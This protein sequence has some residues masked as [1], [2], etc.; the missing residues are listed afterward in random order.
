MGSSQSSYATNNNDTNSTNPKNWSS[1]GRSVRGRKSIQSNTNKT[2]TT[3]LG[4]APHGLRASIVSTSSEQ[5]DHHHHNNHPL[6]VTSVESVH[7]DDI[8]V[9][10]DVHQHPKETYD[11]VGAMIEPCSDDDDDDDTVSSDDGKSC[12]KNSCIIHWICVCAICD[13]QNSFSSFLDALVTT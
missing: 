7:S 10:D 5:L 2:S 4:S 9:D 3:K 13:T 6:D 11:V 8:V 12:A 1:K